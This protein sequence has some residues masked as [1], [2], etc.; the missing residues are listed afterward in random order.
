MLTLLF[1]AITLS[2]AAYAANV[3]DEIGSIYSTDI[4]ADVNGAAI[5][6]YAL[7]GKTA[8]VVE[9][10]ARYG[11]SAAVRKLRIKTA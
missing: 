10:L 8:I 4:L 5:N 1:I 11:F 2:S 3:G 7:D 9:D 6:S